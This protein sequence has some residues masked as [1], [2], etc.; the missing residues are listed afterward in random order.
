[1]LPLPE[2][3]AVIDARR[4]R[5]ALT[6]PR[7]SVPCGKTTPPDLPTSGVARHR[8]DRF[9]VR[10]L[11]DPGNFESLRSQEE[12]YLLSARLLGV[13]GADL[14]RELPQRVDRGAEAPDPLPPDMVLTIR[15]WEAY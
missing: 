6:T 7:N 10:E 11:E 14:R 5:L 2:E 8:A 13:G 9:L 1:V 4:V 15:T 12:V 3:S